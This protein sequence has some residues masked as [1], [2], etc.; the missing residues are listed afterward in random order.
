[1]DKVQRMLDY[2]GVLDSA[3][4][5]D[6]KVLAQEVTPAQL[7]A[8]EHHRHTRWARGATYGAPRLG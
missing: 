7:R 3:G 6:E 2:F 4:V 1:M 5:D 8:D